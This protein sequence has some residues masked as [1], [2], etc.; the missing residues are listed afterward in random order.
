MGAS[1]GGRGAQVPGLCL[2]HRTLQDRA[3]PSS[4]QRPSLN[5]STQ[6]ISLRRAERAFESWNLAGMIEVE[7]LARMRGHIRDVDGP[8][9]RRCD[10][11]HL[12]WV[13]AWARA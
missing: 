9:E 3:P 6:R 13:W 12:K 2:L 11:A 1:G 7:D 5:G 4:S 8:A 10:C